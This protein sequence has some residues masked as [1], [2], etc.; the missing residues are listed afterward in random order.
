MIR[1]YR[2]AGCISAVL[3]ILGSYEVSAREQYPTTDEK[4]FNDHAGIIKKR[5][6]AAMRSL[7]RKA[8]KGDVTMMV[9]T[10]GSLG[11]Y[12]PRPLSVDRFVDDIF[13]DL[14]VDYEAGKNAILLF[15][16][17]EENEFRIVMG[18]NF[19]NPL[20]K[21]AGRIIRQTL[22]PNFRRRRRSRG[23]RLTCARLYH[24]VVS[25]HIRALKKAKRKRPRRGVMQGP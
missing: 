24:K 10:V 15:I 21:K 25:P 23:V 4:C 11:D 7:C 14:D 6:G 12:R 13:N 19:A 20:R 9:V 17:R 8:A 16:S 5:D 22:V 1:C 18:D 2:I 3:L